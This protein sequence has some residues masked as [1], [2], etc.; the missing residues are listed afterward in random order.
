MLNPQN[1]H[2][3]QWVFDDAESPKWAIA[4]FLQWTWY[5]QSQNQRFGLVCSYICSYENTFNAINSRQ[6]HLSE[7]CEDCEAPSAWCDESYWDL[8]L[9]MCWGTSGCSKKLLYSCSKRGVRHDFFFGKS[10]AATKGQSMSK[11]VKACHVATPITE[12]G[13]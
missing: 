7:D 11:H 13:R 8:W 12:L 3:F 9:W 1:Y 5:T 2:C 6:W 10:T 4:I